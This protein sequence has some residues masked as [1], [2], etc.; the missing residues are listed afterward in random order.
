MT[1]GA[2]YGGTSYPIEYRGAYFFGDWSLSWIRY[3]H[4]DDA[5]SVQGSVR[6]FASRTEGPVEI[7]SGPNGD[8]YYLAINIGEL[9]RVA[10]TGE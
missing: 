1:G 7:E 5:G 10:Y 8:L 9:R 2:F 6:E 4:V 3:L